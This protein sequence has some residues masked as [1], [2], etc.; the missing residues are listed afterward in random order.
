MEEREEE[1]KEEEGKDESKKTG[2]WRRRGMRKMVKE[3]EGVLNVEDSAS[4]RRGRMI[5][6]CEDN[7]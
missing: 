1:M 4:K 6:E 7:D 5:I 2:R 3:K